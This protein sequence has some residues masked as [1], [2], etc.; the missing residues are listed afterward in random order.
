MNDARNCE[1]ILVA[2][3]DPQCRDLFY[4]IL[5]DE[6]A[7]IILAPD[8]AHAVRCATARRPDLILMDMDMP[9]LTGLDA[10]RTLRRDPTFSDVPIL[11]ISGAGTEETADRAQGLGATDFIFKPVDPGDLRRRVRGHL[12]VSRRTRR[13]RD[14]LR[15]RQQAEVVRN[16]EE[17]RLLSAIDGNL[18]TLRDVLPPD[19]G[20]PIERFKARA[21]EEVQLWSGDM[22]NVVD[23]LSAKAGRLASAPRVT[24]LDAAVRRVIERLGPVAA[25]WNVD[26][27]CTVH[28]T[29][30]IK[31]D[32]DVLHRVLAGE[33]ADALRVSQ[34]GGAVDVEIRVEGTVGIVRVTTTTSPLVNAKG[35]EV[36]TRTHLAL[37]GFLGVAVE[38]RQA[39]S[40]LEKTYKFP[41][42]G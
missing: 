2:D 20:D 13:L 33:L 18:S 27:R 17:R 36:R 42:G 29:A 31:T 34:E 1:T 35:G 24:P 16:G 38:T 8:G 23:A 9:V 6:V 3:D 25:D 37:L 14:D 26:L 22:R 11:I 40:T 7:E 12:A 39:G 19:S 4:N 41:L 10:A 32:L 21:L 28:S 30:P 15:A 5:H